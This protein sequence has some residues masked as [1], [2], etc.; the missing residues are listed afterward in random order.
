MGR[1]ISYA[2]FE[3]QQHA[4]LRGHGIDNSV[5]VCSLWRKFKT[6]TRCMC[7]LANLLSRLRVWVSRYLDGV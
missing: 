7:H 5:T 3:I 4:G 2:L 1:G 6:S